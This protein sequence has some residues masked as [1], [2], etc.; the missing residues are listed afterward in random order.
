MNMPVLET[1]RLTLRPVIEDDFEAIYAIVGDPET[2]QFLPQVYSR[3]ETRTMWLGGIFRR[4]EQEG[5]SFYAIT[6]GKEDRLIGLCGPLSQ[7]VTLPGETEP[8]SFVEIGYHLNRE[9]WGN[10]YATEAGAAVRDHIFKTMSVERLISI[11]D[12]GNSRSSAVARRI[13]ETLWHEG[14]KFRGDTVDIY[15]LTRADWK[16]MNHNPLFS[17]RE[18][19]EV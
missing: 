18:S 17:Y 11:I 14:A 19:K 5:F 2:M 12:K 13:G 15:S 9:Y 1:N 7:E 6:R 3:D 10:G 16:K 8:R 4:Y